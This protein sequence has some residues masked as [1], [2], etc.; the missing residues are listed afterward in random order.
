MRVALFSP[1][2]SEGPDS[3]L[4]FLIAAYLKFIGTEVA[5]L[6]CDG[7]SAV[8]GRDKPGARRDFAFCARCRAEQRTLERW[9]EFPVE[10]LSSYLEPE[11]AEQTLRWVVGLPDEGLEKAEYRGIVLR[12]LVNAN[13]RQLHG[14]ER[15]D[16][17]SDQTASLRTLIVESMRLFLAVRSFYG[18]YEPDLVLVPESEDYYFQVARAQADMEKRKTVLIRGDAGSRATTILHPDKRTLLT[19]DWVFGELS[20]MRKDCSTWPKE[21]LQL[22]REILSFL[23]IPERERMAHNG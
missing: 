14:G 18:V 2:G 15:P 3:G 1:Y 8:C 19:C 13:F 5:V 9:G 23:G 7:A 10:R 20:G 17:S 22:I 12:D 4:M 6:E 16:G 11:E 21:M